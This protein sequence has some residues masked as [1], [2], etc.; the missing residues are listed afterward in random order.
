MSMNISGKNCV[1]GTSAMKSRKVLPTTAGGYKFYMSRD[2]M[3]YIG[4]ANLL[5]SIPQ[6]VA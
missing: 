1:A 5:M 4:L 3:N 6:C 2:D